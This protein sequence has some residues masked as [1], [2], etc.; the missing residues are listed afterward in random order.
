MS[1]ARSVPSRWPAPC[2]RSRDGRRG[3]GLDAR[4]IVA[5]GTAGMRIAS[6][7]GEV[8]EAIRAGSGLSL[9]VISGEDEGRL[10]Y[11]AVASGVGLGEGSIVVFDTGGGSS[12]FTFGHGSTVDE[13]FSVD[14]GAV[15]FTERFGLARSVSAEVVVA[16]LAAIAADLSR[17]DGRDRPDGVVAMGGAVTNVAAVMHGL[18]DLRP[19]RR[20]GRRPRPRRARPAD[21]DVPAAW[22]PTNDGRSPGCSR[23]GPRSSS[24]V[25]ASSGPSS[26]SSAPTWSRSVIVVCDTAS[27]PKGSGRGS[28]TG[29]CSSTVP[30]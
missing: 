25:P 17:L 19:V 13:R 24:R 7:Q 26:T 3:R 18:S 11:L 6:N 22:T 28:Q 30:A 10:A 21:R 12:Q 23:H 29:T 20:P 27:S 8:V 2:A 14:V 9:E 1:P 4:A 15:R 5:V 16:A